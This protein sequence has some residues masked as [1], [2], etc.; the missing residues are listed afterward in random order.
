MFN[1]FFFKDRAVYEIMCKNTV[2]PGR[3]QM[4]IWRMRI[5]CWIDYNTQLQYVTLITFPLQ[6]LL[7]DAPQCQVIGTLPVLQI[8]TRTVI[9]Y[10]QA[11]GKI[12]FPFM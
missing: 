5:A 9:L 3:P 7:Y 6:Q 11:C 12:L 4:T 8:F 1:T 10:D 2:E